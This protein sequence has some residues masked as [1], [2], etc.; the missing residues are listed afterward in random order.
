MV[1]E[2]TRFAC[3]IGLLAALVMAAA[4]SGCAHQDDEAPA[5]EAWQ[6]YVGPETVEDVW[7]AL[8]ADAPEA[9]RD[10]FGRSCDVTGIPYAVL[11]DSDLERACGL[12]ASQIGGCTLIRRGDDGRVD[13]RLIVVAEHNPD[14]PLYQ[15]GKRFVTAHELAHVCAFRSGFGSL[16]DGD[17]DH[18]DPRVWG[19]DPSEGRSFVWRLTDH[20]LTGS[21]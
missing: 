8:V 3:V 21:P 1:D 16:S 18:S 12:P 17:Y 9:W 7:P 20:P 11:P 10:V 4:G 2:A 5:P 6:D 15:N 14:D 13:A 19:R